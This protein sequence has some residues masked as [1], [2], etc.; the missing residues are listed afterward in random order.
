MKFVWEAIDAQ[1]QIHKGELDA[2]DKVQVTDQLTSQRL[3]PILV[4]GENVG[5]SLSKITIGGSIGIVEKILLFRHI[6][7]MM[8]AG[9][10]IKDIFDILIRDAE[11]EAMKNI[12]QQAM[13]NL[14][15]GQALSVTFQRW[16]K[17]F[18]PIVIGLLKAGEISGNLADVLDQLAI[19]LRKDYELRQ[20]VVG[21][22]IYPAILLSASILLSIFLVTFVLPRIAQAF[23]SSNIPLPPITQFFISLSDFFSSSIFVP[24]FTVLGLAGAAFYFIKVPLG[25]QMLLNIAWRIPLSRNLIK[26]ITLARF[27]RTF[28]NLIQAGLPILNA[29]EV[30]ADSVGNEK[31]KLSILSARPEIQR[32]APISDV[33][34]ERSDFFPHLLTSMMEVGEKSGNLES[35]LRTVSEFYEDDADRLLKALITLIEPLMLL[36]MGLVVGSLALSILLP[37]YKFVGSIR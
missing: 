15:R 14:E 4:K 7:V 6:S 2:K 3:T 13:S 29:L 30:T 23:K 1:G 18:P 19:Q 25:R 12:L 20:K 35:M 5:R 22:M 9:L 8:R 26:K 17:D 33:F 31:Y 21:V 16:P 24:I 34:R 27:S 11:K 32:G 28:A 36:I 10:G 37:V